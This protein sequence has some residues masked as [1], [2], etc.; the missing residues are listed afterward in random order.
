[1]AITSSFADS[2]VANAASL[3]DS[4]AAKA[5]SLASPAADK[6]FIIDITHCCMPGVKSPAA[7]SRLSA[8][9]EHL[10]VPCA[11][12]PRARVRACI[13]R[14]GAALC[15]QLAARPGRH[16]D[17]RASAL[18]SELDNSC[19]QLCARWVCARA[20]RCIAPRERSAQ[21]E[22]RAVACAPSGRSHKRGQATAA[23]CSA[24]ARVVCAQ[25][26]YVATAPPRVAPPGRVPCCAATSGAPCRG[27]GWPA[28]ESQRPA[29]AS[30][31]L[32]LAGRRRSGSAPRLGQHCRY[33]AAAFDVRPA[34]RLRGTPAGG[35]ER[36][37]GK[38]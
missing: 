32:V 3:A 21:T 18:P 19:I 28:R 33:V 23:V 30:S 25:C 36:G 24:G 29:R 5:A 2:A 35:C 37:C 38:V 6:D 1:M 34:G 14:R 15:A 8:C 11:F 17:L 20:A 9:G 10:R 31:A 12:A 27:E 4:A 7:L 13:E 26:M 22:G 16:C